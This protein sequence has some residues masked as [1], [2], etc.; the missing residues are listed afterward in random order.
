MHASRFHKYFHAKAAET[1]VMDL[2]NFVL[3]GGL[4]GCAKP[5][6]YLTPIV[7]RPNMDKAFIL[8]EGQLASLFGL[9]GWR[10]KFGLF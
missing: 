10:K 3:I 5:P 6:V 1:S 8:K 7:D 4:F 9:F 2:C